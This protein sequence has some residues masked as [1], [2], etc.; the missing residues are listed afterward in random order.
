[1]TPAQQLREALVLSA[2]ARQALAA[3]D[4]ARAA[5][6]RRAAAS[7]LAD[8]ANGY[9]HA[10]GADAPSLFVVHALAIAA[11]R[12]AGLAD[13]ATALRDACAHTPWFP[14]LLARVGD[15]TASPPE[16]E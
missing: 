1:M 2:E 10:L 15:G 13:R 9:R 5:P 7:A 12:A 3:G 6:L 8:A 11:C 4:G 16:V 14:E